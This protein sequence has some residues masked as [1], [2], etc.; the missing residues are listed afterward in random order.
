MI[1]AARVPVSTRDSLSARFRCGTSSSSSSRQTYAASK[2]CYPQHQVFHLDGCDILV[3]KEDDTSL[4]DCSEVSRGLPH[5]ALYPVV[6]GSLV[7]ARSLI[8][9]SPHFKRSRTCRPS[10]SRPMAGVKSWFLK[11]SRL[12][13]YSKGPGRRVRAWTLPP[14]KRP[15]SLCSFAGNS[16]EGMMVFRL[17]MCPQEQAVFVCRPT[18]YRAVAEM[19]TCTALHLNV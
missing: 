5:E 17:G 12:P 1:R 6:V 10:Y 8:M 3:P 14:N 11:L 4:R 15:S 18:M 7:T 13:V 19:D 16:T 2:L 9:S